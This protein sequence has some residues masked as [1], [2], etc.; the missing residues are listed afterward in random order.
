MATRRVTGG[1]H[2]VVKW[3]ASEDGKHYRG[4][5]QDM[6]PVFDHVRHMDDKVNSAPKSANRNGWRYAGSIPTAVL[7]DWMNKNGVQFDQFARNEGGVKDKFK[8]W[9]FSR[10]NHKLLARSLR[11]VA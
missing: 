1:G 4:H 2:G 10:E 9:L 11:R 3:H 7:I 5:S 6:Q 8:K